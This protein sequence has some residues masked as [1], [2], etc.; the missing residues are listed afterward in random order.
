[1]RECRYFR[2]T[3]RVQGVW[4]REST[5][6]QAVFH[7]ICG[8]AINRPDGSVEVIACGDVQSVQALRDWLKKGPPLAEVASIQERPY[9]GD[10]PDGFVTA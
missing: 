7:G 9:Q 2:I 6:Q 4:F 8:H 1:M 10:C 3:G 5:R